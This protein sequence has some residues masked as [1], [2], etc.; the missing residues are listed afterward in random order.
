MGSHRIH[1]ESNSGLNLQTFVTLGSNGHC[2]QNEGTICNNT[3]SGD[4]ASGIWG[5]GATSSGEGRFIYG[6]DNTITITGFTITGNVCNSFNKHTIG[7]TCSDT[8]IANNRIYGSGRHGIWIYGGEKVT[9]TGNISMN[10][11]QNTTGT[12][13]D[14]Y[15]GNNTAQ[16][17]NHSLF[18]G[19]VGNITVSDCV[20]RTSIIEVN[21]VLY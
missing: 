15:I 10:C 13:T 5:G 17:V 4:F 7:L 20:D 12:F 9:L 1:I 18:I 14:T 3:V 16:N 11:G 2:D 8:A 19:N 6:K 21:N